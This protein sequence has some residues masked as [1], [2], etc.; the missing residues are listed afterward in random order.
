MN[1]GPVS[2]QSNLDDLGDAI[3]KYAEVYTKK[4][5]PE[6]LRDQANK[7]SCSD[8]GDGNRGLY[9]ESAATAPSAEKLT[10]L[11]PELNW[12]IKRTNR[13][14]FTLGY[15][16]L[17]HKRG[18]LKGQFRRNKKGQIT[19]KLIGQEGEMNRRIRHIGYHA[20]GWLSPRL[21]RYANGEA[22]AAGQRQRAVVTLVLTG[23]RLSVTITN[24]STAA[25]EVA[26]R[27]GYLARALINRRADLMVYVN[28]KLAERTA[29]LN[30]QKLPAP[31]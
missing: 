2:F 9:Q 7:L 14:V 12:R 21:S 17:V 23:T 22:A 24:T 15:Q 27:T 30:A 28:R 5:L 25:L 18:T 8:F 20:S 11:P 1:F 10:A 4:D 13:P 3:L 19:H 31:H 29:E 16:L 26:E 6:I